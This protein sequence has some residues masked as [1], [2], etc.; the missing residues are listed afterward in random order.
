[1]TDNRTIMIDHS[2]SENNFFFTFYKVTD[3]NYI[4]DLKMRINKA[5]TH[6]TIKA[7]T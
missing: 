2:N 1:M 7:I 4:I 6:R 5:C 3:P